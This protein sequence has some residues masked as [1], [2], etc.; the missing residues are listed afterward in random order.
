MTEQYQIQEYSQTA[1]AIAL[2]RQKYGNVAF[3]VATTKGMDAARQARA[4]VKGY[5]VALEKLRVELKAPALERTRLIDAEAKRITADLLAIEE[6]I[7][8]QIKAEEQRKEEEKA[9]KARAE[10]ARL[11]AIAAKISALRNRVSEVANQPA[12]VIRAALDQ[13]MALE[14]APEAFQEFMPDAS[15]ALDETRQALHVALNARIEYELEQARIKDAQEAEA[16]RLQ[17]EREELERLRAAEAARLQAER[18][19]ME[20]QRAELEAKQRALAEQARV[21]K[22][23]SKGKTADPVADLKQALDANPE[24]AK[25]LDAAYQ[26]GYQAGLTAARHVA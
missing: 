6:P 14:L 18:E 20:R 8:Q 9:A 4:E 26:R 1:A 21:T 10:A 19:A 17:A 25:A 2:L 22:L 3:D 13:A 15:A 11:A 5:R 12:E 7:D 16:A 24:T 23:P